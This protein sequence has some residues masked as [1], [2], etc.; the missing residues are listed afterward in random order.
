MYGLELFIFGY[1]VCLRRNDVA[2]RAGMEFLGEMA[3]YL[4]D[5]FGWS[6]SLGPVQ[7]NLDHEGENAWERFFELLDEFERDS[8]NES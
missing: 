5:R 4:R 3:G 1:L 8:R 7:T 6:L 2:D